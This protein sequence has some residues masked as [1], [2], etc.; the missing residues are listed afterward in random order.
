MDEGASSGRPKRHQERRLW[1]VDGSFPKF[2][3]EQQSVSGRSS[4][5]DKAPIAYAAVD[6]RRNRRPRRVVRDRR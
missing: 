1:S 3:G 4:E 6:A 5:Y 2:S